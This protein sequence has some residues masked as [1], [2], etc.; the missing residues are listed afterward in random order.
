MKLQDY[1]KKPTIPG[2]EFRQLKVHKDDG[3]QFTELG[4]FISISG[5]IGMDEFEYRYPNGFGGDPIQINCSKLHPGV[6]KGFHLH[7]NQ[8]DIFY[9]PDKLLVNLIDCR[10]YHEQNL[11]GIN[12]AVLPRMRFIID[13]TVQ[14][15]VPRGIAHGIS[16][17]Y[18]KD[19]ILI[20]FV[21]QK[22]NPEDE[23]RIPWDVVGR[24]I[25]DLSKE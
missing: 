17:P 24:D 1:E 25:W 12:L 21:D 3:G 4:H 16:N 8:T 20:Y 11:K 14:V 2:V 15:I 23:W 22:F 18:N 7:K 10:P 5:E 9:T 6:I 13:E 19:A